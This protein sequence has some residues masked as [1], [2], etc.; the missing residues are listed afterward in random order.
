MHL[1]VNNRPKHAQIGCNKKNGMC[2]VTLKADG[3]ALFKKA[4]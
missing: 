2:T 3:V 1:Q 4:R